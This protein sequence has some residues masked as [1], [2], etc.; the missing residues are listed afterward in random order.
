MNYIEILKCPITNQSL[1]L[2]DA[3]TLATADH[4]YKY[5]II[6][7]I[8]MLNNDYVITAEDKIEN[9]FDA[10]NRKVQKFYD[11]KGW[12][13]N[14]NG[15]YLDA[16]EFEDLRKDVSSEYLSRCHYRVSRYLNSKGKYFLDAGSGAIQHKEYLEY[17]KQY[18]YRICIDIS[19]EALL[20]CKQKLGDKGIYI[21]SNLNNIPLVDNV[22]DSFIA[23]N[24]VYHIP[25]DEQIHAIREMYRVTKQNGKG[26]VVYDWYK[27]SQWM[28]V[29]LLPFRAFEF[30]KNKF[31]R[32]FKITEEYGLYFY[33]H[34]LKYLRANLG[35]GFDVK[36]WRSISVPFMKVYIHKYL[37]GKY[38]LDL[39]WK[40]EEKNQEKCGLNGE[41][42]MFTFHKD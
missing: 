5:P 24:V 1:I 41:Y 40:F 30:F 28:N 33:V 42:P 36:C 22:V 29:S 11:G 9:T 26:V 15:D 25:A 23:I 4:K 21:C 19:I 6:D 7:G 12:K 3:V 37:F 2:L 18:D 16:I 27:Y 31:R 14:D 8:L 17:S 32:L 34:D 39:I 38:L 13:K 10:I 20:E 35:L